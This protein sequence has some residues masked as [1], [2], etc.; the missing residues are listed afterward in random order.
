MPTALFTF[1]LFAEALHWIIA[2]FFIWV[3]FHY[4]FDFVA[5][6][7]SDTLPERLVAKANTYIWLTDPLCLTQKDF[8]DCQGI[9]V[10]VLGIEVD[11]SSFTAR[12]PRDKLEKAILA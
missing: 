9:V 12:P 8:K 5:T 1:G 11:T 10:T 2:S 6:F 3:L 4:L 7:R